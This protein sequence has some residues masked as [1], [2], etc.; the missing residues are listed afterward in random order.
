MKLLNIIWCFL[1]VSQSLKI[2]Y[3][4]LMRLVK[5]C[6]TILFCYF[7]FLVSTFYKQILSDIQGEYIGYRGLIFR[8]KV[9][10][11]IG[12]QEF[13]RYLKRSFN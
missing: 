10:L 5:I 4:F 13:K 6:F 7:H 1:A 2:I 11:F 9:A 3:Y 8:L 12:F